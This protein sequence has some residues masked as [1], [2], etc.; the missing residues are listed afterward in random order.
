MK[1]SKLGK[2]TP[3]V[4]REDPAFEGSLRDL[5]N[6]GE[7]KG[8]IDSADAWVV[9]RELRNATAHEYTDA[10]LAAFFERIRGEAPRVLALRG[11]I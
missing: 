5:C 11:Q 3:R 4:L 8:W 6:F 1:H 2:V 7:K 9:L 10:N